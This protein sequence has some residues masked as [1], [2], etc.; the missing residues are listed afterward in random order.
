MKMM[1]RPH[2]GCLARDCQDQACWI[3]SAAVLHCIKILAVQMSQMLQLIGPGWRSATTSSSFVLV[4]NAEVRGLG[5]AS[6]L[7]GVAT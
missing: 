2:Q 3:E 6:M 4:A 1:T 7:P 5:P